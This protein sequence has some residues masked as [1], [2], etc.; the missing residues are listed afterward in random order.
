MVSGR[1]SGDRH[2]TDNRLGPRSK[3]QTRKF[4]SLAV[5]DSLIH[6][7][8]I[9]VSS[10]LAH[11]VSSQDR[12][13]EKTSLT[14]RA[15][16]KTLPYQTDREL[17]ACL[18]FWDSLQRAYGSEGHR[19]KDTITSLLDAWQGWIHCSPDRPD[20]E[21]LDA[22]QWWLEEFAQSDIGWRPQRGETNFFATSRVRQAAHHFLKM[23]QVHS[24]E[25]RR[26][27]D[28]RR[29]R[30]LRWEAVEPEK[31]KRR[32]SEQ[33]VHVPGVGAYVG[34]RRVSILG[35]NGNVEDNW[36]YPK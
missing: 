4:A 36:R 7:V 19:S 34:D 33:P 25:V 15:L 35:L 11:R 1:F 16:A 24:A 20:A 32:F 28:I 18:A 26:I 5:L 27:A 8:S 23:H 31:R 30:E 12:L 14:I 3:P 2:H 10:F 17:R 9:T 22:T 29:A 6:E 21:L 13:T